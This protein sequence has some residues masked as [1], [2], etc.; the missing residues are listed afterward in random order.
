MS[1]NKRL[2][3][4]QKPVNFADELD[5][6]LAAPALK[7]SLRFL[8]LTDPVAPVTPSPAVIEGTP[9]VIEEAPAVIEEAPAVSTSPATTAA[10]AVITFTPSDIAPSPADTTS[11]DTIASPAVI[12]EVSEN[13]QLTAGAG[14]TAS[15][16]VSRKRIH[17]CLKVQDG[18][19]HVEQATYQILWN[20]G[21]PQ[22]D[23]HRIC[24]MGLPRLSKE[25][26]VHQRNIGT[27]IRRLIQ[28]QSI[29]IIQKEMSDLRT[30]RTYRIFGYR[31]ILER[32]KAA[33][34]EWVIRGRGVEFVEPLTGRP[35]FQYIP[36]P[37]LEDIT[38]GDA[39]TAGDSPAITASDSPAVTAGAPPAITAGPLG[40]ENLGKTEEYSS[41]STPSILRELNRYGPADD[42]AVQKLVRAC[43]AHAPDCV[44]AEISYFIEQK[45][46]LI[47][48][49]RIASPVG[50]LLTA[51]PKC[52]SGEA[53]AMYREQELKRRREEETRRKQQEA[54]IEQWTREQ[55]ALLADPNASEEDKRF[56]RQI[57]GL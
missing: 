35:L 23:G 12:A 51:V 37:P 25:A 14:D 2:S 45:A 7:P 40:K 50:F 20:S 36:Q 10:P 21:V 15:P 16:A 31:E 47:R 39:I 8:G 57:L 19:S 27:I 9:A 18:H 46:A 13:Q 34:L 48:T 38:A 11:P 53:F 5:D 24:R 42:D 56:A 30:A 49:G 43:R 4:N 3:R 26:C 54:E 6:M 44:E 55:Q 17:Q 1:H 52:F 32:R 29:E 28:K 41:S 33:G 22:P